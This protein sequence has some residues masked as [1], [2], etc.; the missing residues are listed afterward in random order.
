VEEEPETKHRADLAALIVLVAAFGVAFIA[1]MVSTGFVQRLDTA[2]SEA[3]QLE[4]LSDYPGRPTAASPESAAPLNYLMLSSD[5]DK[6]LNAAVVV[7]VNA[8]R[9]DLAL[10]VLPPTVEVQGRGQTLGEAFIDQPLEVWKDVEELTGTRIDHQIIIWSDR[11]DGVIRALGGVSLHAGDSPRDAAELYNHVMSSLNKTE[12]AHRA[13][14]VMEAVLLR[15][16]VQDAVSDP[17]RFNAVMDQITTCVQVD[18]G[19]SAEE[20]RDTV[21]QLRISTD[22]IRRVEVPV[23]PAEAIVAKDVAEATP[24]SQPLAPAQV[25]TGPS[26]AVMVEPEWVDKLQLSFAADDFSTLG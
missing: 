12:R 2:I 18:K 1:L 25:A 16:T 3:R 7:H 17:D 8:E 22:A 14:E 21:M 15:I 24:V 20:V 6:D 19:L 26:E 23:V 11:L 13:S 5:T 9:T 4:N 10:V